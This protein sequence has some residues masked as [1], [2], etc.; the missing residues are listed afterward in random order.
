MK[1]VPVRAPYKTAPQAR[2]YPRR[3]TYDEV[4]MVFPKDASVVDPLL[5]IAVIPHKS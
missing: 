3:A 5:P 1:A 4:V 2:W